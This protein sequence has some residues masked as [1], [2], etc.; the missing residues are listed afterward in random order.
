M[1]FAPMEAT[2]TNPVRTL[3]EKPDWYFS[4]RA[5]DIRIRVETVQQML[6]VAAPKRVLDIGCGDGSISLP[7]LTEK[8]TVTLLDLSA[9]MLSLAQSRTPVDL[10]HNVTLV[11]EDFMRAPLEPGSFDVILCLGVLAHVEHPETL[12]AKIAASLKPDGVAV[13]E[14][15]DATH[16]ASRTVAMVDWLWTRFRP[17]PYRLQQITCAGVRNLFSRHRLDEQTTFRYAAPL[18]GIHRLLSQSTMYRL[19]R[20]M[21]GTAVRNRN[22]W[23]ANEYISVFAAKSSEAKNHCQK[24]LVGFIKI[25]ML[26]PEFL[27]S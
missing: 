27:T 11:N 20:W 19:S 5:F 17:A 3:F 15:T 12:I 2:Q 24:I 4:R 6:N 13:V 16:F 25:L 7:L 10:R 9:K 21:F 8:T 1:E 14:Y 26:V 18:P 22:R 23:L